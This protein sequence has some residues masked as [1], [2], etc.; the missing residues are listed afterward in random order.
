MEWILCSERLPSDSKEVI[1]TMKF[2]K[3]SHVTTAFYRDGKWQKY[4]LTGNGT[5][6]TKLVTAWMPFPEPYMDSFERSTANVSG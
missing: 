4:S 1:V 5:Y 3:L 2:G 6:Q